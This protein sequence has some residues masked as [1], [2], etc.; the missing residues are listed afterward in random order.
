MAKTRKNYPKPIWTYDVPN[1][2]MPRAVKKLY[3]YICPFGP[4]TCWLYNRRLG[5][6]IGYSQATVKR[7][8][9]WG[10]DHGL[11][12]ITSSG[13][14]HRRIH[15]RYYNSPIDWLVKTALPKHK[16][17]PVRT[18]GKLTDSELNDRRNRGLKSLG[19]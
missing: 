4:H 2:M 7:A 6:K 3:L 18:P 14:A 10:I 9:R 15:V 11:W 19:F 8:I 12:W 16:L 1:S 5:S 17:P 13:G